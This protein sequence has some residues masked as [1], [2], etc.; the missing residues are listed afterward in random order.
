MNT[1]HSDSEKSIG[2]IISELTSEI[3]TLFRQEIGLVKTE[4]S[5]KVG[6]AKNGVGM[7]VVG[8]LIVYAGFMVLLGAAV[9]GLALVMD[10]WLAALLM[11]VLVLIIGGSNAGQWQFQQL[12]AGNLVPEKSM[13][14]VKHDKDLAK[15]HATTSNETRQPSA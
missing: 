2:T 11:A 4:I 14:Q 13:D 10:L 6:Q 7:L 8:A 5:E 9:A 1:T 3:N 12:K 15:K